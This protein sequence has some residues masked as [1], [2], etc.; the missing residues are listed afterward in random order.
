M[1]VVRTADNR[2]GQLAVT[3]F[4]SFSGSVLDSDTAMTALQVVILIVYTIYNFFTVCD[5]ISLCKIKKMGH[6]HV[7]F[8]W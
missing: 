8:A 2:N 3:F 1:T 7:S 5:V 6:C 4:V